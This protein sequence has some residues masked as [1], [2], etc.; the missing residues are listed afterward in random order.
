MVEGS[1]PFA[2]PWHARTTSRLGAQS[3]VESEH[4]HMKNHLTVDVYRAYVLDCKVRGLSTKT[5][6]SYGEVLTQFVDVYGPQPIQDIKPSIIREYLLTRQTQGG[7]HL[8]YRYLRAMFLFWERETDGEYISPTHKVQ[9][10]RVN[11]QPLPPIPLNDIKRM[12]ET[13]GQDFHGIRDKA[14]IL[15]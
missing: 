10:P 3:L 11:R 5:M 2:H 12:V 7:R 13:C 9:A 6:Q 4:A 8:V 15:S 1:S 14:I